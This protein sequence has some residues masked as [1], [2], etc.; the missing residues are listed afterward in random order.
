MTV[1]W[2]IQWWNLIFVAPLGL[3]LMYLGLYTASGITFGDADMDHDFDADSDF[4]A[5]HDLGADADHDVDG[6]HDASAEH[7]ADTD[8]DADSDHDAEAD[9]AAGS[10]T[11]IATAAMGWL[12][13]GRVPLSILLMVALMTWGAAGLICSAI[14]QDRGVFAAWISIPVAAGVSVLITHFVAAFIGKYLPLNETSARRRH[15]LLGLTGQ[16]MLPINDHFGMVSV[17]DATGDLYQVACRAAATNESINKGEP[18][19][20]VAYNS[21]QQ[22]FLVERETMPAGK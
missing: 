19:K 3:A 17:R 7:D 10:Q 16:A 1:P 5:D 2:L 8:G 12:G 21:S 14:L 18:V 22:M 15:A 13:V 9:D 6:D 4:D 20:L 11:S